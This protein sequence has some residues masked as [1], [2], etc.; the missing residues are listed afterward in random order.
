MTK[1]LRPLAAMAMAA[2][3]LRMARSI[4]LPLTISACEWGKSLTTFGG[5]PT[6]SAFLNPLGGRGLAVGM[7]VLLFP[8]VVVSCCVVAGGDDQAKTSTIRPVANGRGGSTVRRA[9]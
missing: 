4:N 2:P 5:R 3:L 9:E 7:A 1:R 8:S 6:A